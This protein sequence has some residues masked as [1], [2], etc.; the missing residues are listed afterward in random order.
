MPVT[1]GIFETRVVRARTNAARGE[2]CGQRVDLA[3]RRAI[4]D[5][6]LIPMTRDDVLQLP[7]EA[8]ARQDAVDEVR[9]IE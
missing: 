2:P 6:C 5:A 3:A 8:G 9:T 4:D 7:L 1:V